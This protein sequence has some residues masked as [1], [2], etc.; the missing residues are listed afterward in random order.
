MANQEDIAAPASI[1]DC[2][3]RCTRLPSCEVFELGRGGCAPNSP[4]N[5]TGRTINCFLIGGYE[6]RTRHN[7]DRVS[8]CVRS[9]WSAAN[10]KPAALAAN[11]VAAQC[12]LRTRVDLSQCLKRATWSSYTLG[13]DRKVWME[14]NGLACWQGHGADSVPNVSDYTTTSLH[15]C[16]QRCEA[17][18]ACTAIEFGSHATEPA[19]TSSVISKV[20]VA[21]FML[22]R[23]A[24]A[25]ITLPPYDRPMLSSPFSLEGI[26]L[27]ADP[28]TPLGLATLDGSTFTRKY[29]R[30]DV[31]LDCSTLNP[32]ISFKSD[33]S[34]SPAPAPAPSPS[35]SIYLPKL[36]SSHMVL[37]AD[38]PS[39]SGW[40]SGDAYVAVLASFKD[41]IGHTVTATSHRPNSSTSTTN[42]TAWTID[43]PAQP[44]SL[45]PVD[46]VLRVVG[47]GGT[48]VMLSDVLFG[49]VFLCSVRTNANISIHTVSPLSFSVCVPHLPS[50]EP[51]S[52]AGP[53]EHGVCCGG[54]V[55]GRRGHCLVQYVGP[56]PRGCTEER[57]RCAA[58]GYQGEPVWRSWLGGSIAYDRLRS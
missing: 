6:N 3:E 7:P 42:A 11:E 47:G 9:S 56:A 52:L 12:G 54:D 36:V 45:T 57:L 44:A 55:R 15:A 18:D 49:D 2:C 33:P 22:A 1:A 17:H 29:S 43:L 4:K 24:G 51:P 19:V 10:D 30:A 20:T 5:C 34:P 35:L 14:H 48:P 25:V 31:S 32:T 40:T 28:G 27:D 26:D 41:A 13:G 53:V 21:T 50:A 16:K 8:G 23:G 39:V 46:I 37:Q 38:R 58:T